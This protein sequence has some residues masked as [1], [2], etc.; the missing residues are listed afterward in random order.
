MNNDLEKLLHVP[1]TF[2][3]WCRTGLAK[4]LPSGICNC[5]RC[6]TE[7]G[8]PVTD[9]TDQLAEQEAKIADEKFESRPKIHHT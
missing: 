6:R 2:S 3:R 9:V 5:R 4:Y 7:R 8:E 1:F